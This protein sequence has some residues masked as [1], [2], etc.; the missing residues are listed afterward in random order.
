[1]FFLIGTIEMDRSIPSAR[2]G[3]ATVAHCTNED[4]LDKLKDIE[5][6]HV[7][8]NLYGLARTFMFA[9]AA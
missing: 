6:N 8:T 5:G 7:S 9:E 4:A 3:L 1:M 2:V